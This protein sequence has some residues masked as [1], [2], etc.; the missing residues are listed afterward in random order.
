MHDVILI[1]RFFLCFCSEQLNDDAA[2]FM[3]E[4][5]VSHTLCFAD[6]NMSMQYTQEMTINVEVVD[7]VVETQT[8]K[9]EE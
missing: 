1:T 2:D 6:I 3:E 8:S 7:K 5:N 4:L 9:K